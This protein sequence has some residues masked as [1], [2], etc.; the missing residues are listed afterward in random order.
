MQEFGTVTKVSGKVA[1][2]RV[3]RHS[4]CGSCGMCGMS[5]AQRHVDF[6][7]INTLNAKQGDTVKIEIKEGGAWKVATVAYLIP[8]LFGIALFVLG[9]LLSFPDW[10]NLVM[11]LLGCAIA[12]FILVIIDRVK[13]HKWMQSPE[14]IEIINNKTPEEML[15]KNS[16]LDKIEPEQ[17]NNQPK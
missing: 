13:K 10:A 15:K 8:L 2:V 7:T 6:Q 5:S 14:L 4:A 17:Q 12:F 1:T 16:N 3:G 9:V 11:F